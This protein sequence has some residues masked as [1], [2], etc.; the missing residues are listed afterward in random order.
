VLFP[1]PMLTFRFESYQCYTNH[2][3][4]QNQK[5]SCFKKVRTCLLILLLFS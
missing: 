5:P 3:I 2:L 1:V 4:R